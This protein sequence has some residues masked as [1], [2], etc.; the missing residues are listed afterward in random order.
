M[1]GQVSIPPPHPDASIAGP[2]FYKE[3]QAPKY[4][5]GIGSLL[6][7]NCIEFVLFFVLRYAFI[8]EN[9]KKAKLR[10]E[11]AASG[12]QVSVQDTAFANMTDKQNPK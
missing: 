6:V 2:F 12:R 7:A 10:E 5:L 3:S 4:G 11:L 9:R 8:Y 1:R